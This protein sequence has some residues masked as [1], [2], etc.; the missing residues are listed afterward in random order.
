VA[1][2]LSPWDIISRT[3]TP[4]EKSYSL[5]EKEGLAC[6]HG[7]KHFHSYLLGHKFILQ[8]YHEPLR[9]LLSKTVP[10]HASSRIQRWAWTLAAYEYVIVCRLINADA[11]SRLPLSYTP[12]RPLSQQS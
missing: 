3:L 10:P 7:V 8:T 12:V 5:M 9:T 4:T 2:E 6:V 11:M 1:A